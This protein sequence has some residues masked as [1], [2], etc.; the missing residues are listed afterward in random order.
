M[1]Q[2][3]PFNMGLKDVSFLVG[4]DPYVELSPSV[5]RYMAR[6]D[7]VV[8]YVLLWKVNIATPTTQPLPYLL[9]GASD[10]D[11]G[12]MGFIGVPG[13]QGYSKIVH[14]VVQEPRNVE[15]IKF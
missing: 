2:T 7:L 13:V 14:E 15:F 6:G 11:A 3:I 9:D 1:G 12:V 8:I 5:E 4:V 10:Q